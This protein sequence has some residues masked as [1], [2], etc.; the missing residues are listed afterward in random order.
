LIKFGNRYYDP[1]TARWTQA[2]LFATAPGPGQS[3]ASP[4]AYAGDDPINQLDP[5][6]NAWI[7]ASG[8]WSC[9][10]G[11]IG[12]WWIKVHLTNSDI[13]ALLYGW[14]TVSLIIAWARIA[15]PWV[16]YT[17]AA[18]STFFWYINTLNRLGGFQGVNFYIATWRPATWPYWYATA[19]PAGWWW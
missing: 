1:G 9:C 10:W 3:N 14:A 6:G 4:Y 15:P 17:W 8:G 19:W 13:S 2:D 7:Y 12:Y 11:A 16:W 18:I 5:S